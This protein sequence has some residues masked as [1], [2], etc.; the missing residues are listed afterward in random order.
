MWPLHAAVRKRTRFWRHDPFAAVRD[1]LES[2][3]IQLDI[4]ENGSRRRSRGAL[5][6]A[7]CSMRQTVMHVKTVSSAATPF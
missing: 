7:R 1:D 3:R 4:H 2:G 6:V 5:L